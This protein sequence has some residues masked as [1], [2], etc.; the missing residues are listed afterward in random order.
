[1]KN[2]LWHYQLKRY[3]VTVAM[4]RQMF[5]S[6][7]QLQWQITFLI[8][9]AHDGFGLF[10]TELKV[11]W[12]C[13]VRDEE[14]LASSLLF[15]AVLSWSLPYIVK[16]DRKVLIWKHNGAGKQRTWLKWIITGA[17]PW[18]RMISYTGWNIRLAV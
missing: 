18:V 12:L 8:L 11:V 4:S 15:L 5:A 7:D 9:V 14:K 13:T 2:T 17:W 3:F 16:T 6:I 10:R 1:M